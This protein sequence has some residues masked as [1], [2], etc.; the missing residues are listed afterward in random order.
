MLPY[1]FGT[2]FV[3]L[4]VAMFVQSSI[5]FAIRDSRRKRGYQVAGDGWGL[6]FKRLFPPPP[7]E[8][9]PPRLR[10]IYQIAGKCIWVAGIGIAAIFVFF[11]VLVV[12]G[13][14]G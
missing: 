5:M 4:V 13:R 9:D 8:E 3:V 2:P 12:L 11:I 7:N 14:R 1:I 10:L 6:V